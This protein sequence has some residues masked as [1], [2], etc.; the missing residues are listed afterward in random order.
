MNTNKFTEH[1]VNSKQV[2]KGRLLNVYRDVV[3]L[4]S[5]NQSSRE[6][7]KHPGAAVV[8]PWMGNDKIIMVRQFR[9]PVGTVMLEL[10]AG[11]IDPNESPETT[12]QR[13]MAEEIGYRANILKRI[14]R[15]HTCVGYSDE[16]LHLFWAG[17]LEHDQLSA[18]DDETIEVIEIEAA[19]AIEMVLS[20]DITD[21]KTL[22]GLFWLKEILSSKELRK[23]FIQ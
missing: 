4:P 16:L 1:T 17:N 21:A 6:Y 5:Q 23:K 22:I 14:C 3:R 8:I 10:P 11:K 19:R 18:D 12:I 2:Y 15:I 20:G 13:E 7:I 9:Y